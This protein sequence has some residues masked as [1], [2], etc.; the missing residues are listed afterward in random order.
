MKFA[1]VNGQREEAR[2]N[3]SGECPGCGRLMVARCG[4]VRVRHWAHKQ[5]S[6]CDPWWENETEWH[7]AWKDQ[8]PADWQE[9][10]HHAE[11]G[12][13]HIADV[14]TPRGWVIEFQHSYLK[15]EERRSRN[16]FYPKLIWVVDGTRRK[17]D[18]EQFGNAWQ[19][20]I[21]VGG[22]PN[23]RKTFPDSCL[24]LR[25]WEDS[26]SPIFFDLS[27][28]QVLWW[29]L[30]RGVN[31]SAYL[32]P[33]CRAKFIESHGSGGAEIAA[34]EF[35]EFVSEIPK[36]VAD[37]ESWTARQHIQG[38]QRYPILGNRSRRRF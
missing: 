13:R 25:E 9:I 35:D 2:P 31:G 26:P 7:R 24:L 1:L 3:L 28:A 15:P 8:F 17:R 11:T 27:R 18:I 4:E 20:G 16:V 33:Y 32:A 37:Y 22:N 30:A 36:L 14:K 29:V 34:R 5:S 23:L 10:V 21:P 12:E 38:I 19:E 6:D